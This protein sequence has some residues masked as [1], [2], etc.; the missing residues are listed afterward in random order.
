MSGY[1]SSISSEIGAVA[2]AASHDR[3]KIQSAVHDVDMTLRKAIANHASRLEKLDDLPVKLISLGDSLLT[4]KA[5]I[6]S[7]EESARVIREGQHVLRDKVSLLQRQ[8]SQTAAPADAEELDVSSAAQS[9]IRDLSD[10]DP[11][12]RFVALE[13]LVHHDDADLVSFVVPM[14]KDS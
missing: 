9:L 5:T 1:K 10:S 11:N 13:K 6:S 2:V 12:V 7:I 8:S 4:A 3:E 14:L